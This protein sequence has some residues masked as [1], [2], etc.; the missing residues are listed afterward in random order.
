MSSSRLAL[1]LNPP[2]ED[3]Q[4]HLSSGVPPVVD[5]AGNVDGDWDERKSNKDGYVAYQLVPGGKAFV[6]VRAK[7]YKDYLLPVNMPDDSTQQVN[8]EPAP[9][10]AADALH[11]EG[12]DIKLANGSRYVHCQATSYLLAQKFHMGVDIAPLLYPGFNGYNT[13]FLM[14]VVPKQVGLPEFRPDADLQFYNKSRDFLAYMTARGKRVEATLLCDC[15]VMG[16]DLNAQRD[17]TEKMYEIL[18]EFPWMLCQLGNEVMKNGVYWR[19]LSQPSGVF[20]SH[21]SSLSGEPCPLPPGNYSTAHMSR[22]GGG[23]YLDAQSYYMITGYDGFPGVHGPCIVNETRGA[24]ES[25]NSDRRTTDR[26]YFRKIA[27]AMKAWN[28]GTFHCDAGIHSDPMGTNQQACGQE[29]I[30]A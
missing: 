20:W 10:T 2:L 30:N 17:H 16:F 3:V 13:T 5:D 14:S 8:L 26:T 29:F 18:R 15:D 4:T 25:E 24:S 28:G 27:A 12:E 1:Q 7:G 9:L 22:S 6:L 19:D 23:A 11:T 21:G